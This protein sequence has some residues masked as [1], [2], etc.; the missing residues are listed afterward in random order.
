MEQDLKKKKEKEN[1]VVNV[2]KNM[3]IVKNVME[4]DGM[5]RKVINARNASDY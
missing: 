2:M 5:K 3:G 1:H 4:R